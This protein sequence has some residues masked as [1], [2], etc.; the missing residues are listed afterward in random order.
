[1]RRVLPA[2]T[3]ELAELQPFGRLLLVLRRAVVASFALGARQADDVAHVKSLPGLGA[4]VSALGSSSPEPR[5]P[6]SG[7]FATR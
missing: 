6:S 1:M 4:R 5:V 2:K 7:S 3:A